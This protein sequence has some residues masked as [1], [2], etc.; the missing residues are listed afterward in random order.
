MRKGFRK[1]FWIGFTAIL[2]VLILL[3]VLVSHTNFPAVGLTRILNRSI[4]QTM[5]LKVAVG[6]VRGDLFNGLD[7]TDITVYTPE[8]KE[9]RMQIKE[10]QLRYHLTDLL[11]GRLIFS[12]IIL[13]EPVAHIDFSIRDRFHRD[14]SSQSS[15]SEESGTGFFF[16]VGHL[17]IRNGQF[18][19]MKS[20]EGTLTLRDIHLEGGLHGRG[21]KITCTLESAGFYWEEKDLQIQHIQSGVVWSE[22]SLLIQHTDITTTGS[23]IHCSG[24]I[25]PL[26]SSELH[27]RFEECT[28]SL[29]EI[30]QFF[31]LSANQLNGNISMDAVLIGPLNQL[32]IVSEIAGMV[33]G[34]VIDHLEVNMTAGRKKINFTQFH[35]RLNKT[36]LSGSGQLFVEKSDHYKLN[37]SFEHLDLSLVQGLNV[38]TD[39]NGEISIDGRGFSRDNLNIAADLDV[40]ESSVDSYSFNSCVGR[41]R[42]SNQRVATDGPMSLRKGKTIWEVQGEMHF[43]GTVK[44]KSDIRTEDLEALTRA[45]HIPSLRGQGQANLSV[46]GSISD[47]DI[48][49]EVSIDN[50]ANSK[51]SFAHFESTI[52]L[53]NLSN[54]LQGSAKMRGTNGTIEKIPITQLL[55]IISF[56]GSSLQIDSLSAE[57]SEAGVEAKGLLHVEEKL[58]SLIL[59]HVNSHFREYAI[60]NTDTVYLRFGKNGAFNG[61]G[62]FEAGEGSF[63]FNAMIDSTGTINTELTLNSINLFPVIETMK[64]AKGIKGLA[65]GTI[66]LS[67]NLDLPRC[68]L[69]VSIRDGQVASISFDTL[70]CVAQYNNER[71]E[72]LELV[73]F[74]R[75]KRVLLC[76]GVVP[77]HLSL[78]GDHSVSIPSTDEVSMSVNMEDFDLYPVSKFFPSAKS[79]QGLCNADITIERTIDDPGMTIMCSVRGAQYDIL[80]FGDIR[81]F[82]T[83]ETGLFKVHYLESTYGG[84]EYASTGIIPL[85]LSWP[86][87]DIYSSEEPVDINLGMTG[88][89]PEDLI[90]V[91]TNEITRLSGEMDLR[92]SLSGPLKSPVL[93]GDLSLKKGFLQLAE[94]ENPMTDVQVEVTVN[95]TLIVIDRFVGKMGRGAL[96]EGGFFDSL[97]RLITFRKKHVP[98][99]FSLQGTIDFT[100]WRQIV[101][102]LKFA[103]EELFLR[104]LRQDI[105]LVADT[106]LQLSGMKYPHISGDII[107]T[108]GFVREALKPRE[109]LESETTPPGSQRMGPSLELN[110]R[111]PGNFWVEGSDYIQELSV[112]LKGDLQVLKQRTGPEFQFFGTS[113]TVRGKYQI[114]GNVFHITQGNMSFGGISEFNPT[115]NIEAETRVGNEPIYLNLGGTLL[116]PE[117]KLWSE[118]GYSEKDVI[119]LL[120]LGWTTAAVDTV[121]VSDALGSKATNV[122]GNLI[123]GELA[124]RARQQL[125]VDTFEITS[126]AGSEL[127]PDNTQVTVGK[128]LSPRMYLEYSRRLAAESEQEIELEYRLNRHLSFLGTRDRRGLYHLQLQFKFDY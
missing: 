38:K 102:D 35:M 116:Q 57:N 91:F 90:T 7:L 49:G 64:V 1:I 125:G 16:G 4:P 78:R 72:I 68:E 25:S 115:L 51:Y 73:V 32:R 20:S 48:E 111:I 11:G 122:I 113:E 83:Y 44:A 2:L 108:Q 58:N 126:G 21:Q 87:T 31:G 36:C 124:R 47:P 3:Y 120:T 24:N 119:S 105:D 71:V 80:Q 37:T 33:N 128:Y 74:D 6:E 93:I 53:K 28:I 50:L 103:G 5:G 77:L 121:G 13:I 67:G 70:S 23:V 88:S 92:F 18:S 34:Y 69:A 107:I 30:G 14:S 96:D 66:T 85:N 97:V 61:N 101:Y 45:F 15:Q 54:T 42:L 95:D 75:A 100:D 39:L 99:Q 26:N 63:N 86:L 110:V 104:P 76:Q 22:D 8:K 29:R 46:S 17:Q 19:Y 55:A 109:E 98:G 27:L 60:A 89:I 12:D 43:D 123:E 84:T 9:N 118:S 94:L 40:K 41:C 106:D 82:F 59:T 112:E 52:H 56:D 65:D 79:F 81:G 127:V 10:V 114:Y 62:E 117:V